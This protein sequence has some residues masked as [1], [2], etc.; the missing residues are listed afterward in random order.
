MEEI[1]AADYARLARSANQNQATATLLR[2]IRLSELP[3]PEREYKFH[4]VRGWRFDLCWASFRVAVEVEGGTWKNG[5]HNRGQGYEDDC[6]KYNEAALAGWTLLRFTTSQIT[7]GEA[8]EYIK[9]AL[10]G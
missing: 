5:R 1:P 2:D 6:V 3:E 9:R 7:R 10:K 4:A 8:V